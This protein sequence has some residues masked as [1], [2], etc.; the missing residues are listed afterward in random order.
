VQ[1]W[2]SSS[3]ASLSAG[4]A[5]AEPL[6]VDGF[7]GT[8]N[9]TGGDHRPDASAVSPPAAGRPTTTWTSSTTPRGRLCVAGVQQDSEGIL[10]VQTAGP[11]PLVEP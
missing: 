5:G 4:I 7:E 10:G 1:G 11:Q 3:A 6:R 9:A 2:C 8:V